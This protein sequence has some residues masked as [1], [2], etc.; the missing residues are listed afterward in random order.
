MLTGPSSKGSI[1]LT[2]LLLITATGMGATLDFSNEN[3]WATDTDLTYTE[4]T[5][6]CSTYDTSVVLRDADDPSNNITIS[7]SPNH[8]ITRGELVGNDNDQLG[9]RAGDQTIELY[10]GAGNSTNHT[11]TADVTVRTPS[12]SISDDGSGFVGQ[13]LGAGTGADPLTLAVGVNDLQKDQLTKDQ[14]SFRF[15]SIDGK[16]GKDNTYD[17]RL[18]DKGDM[19]I[20]PILNEYIP[21]ND[22]LTVHVNMTVDGETVRLGTKDF[23]PQTF[24]YNPRNINRQT[25]PQ[26]E[27][28]QFL[29]LGYLYRFDQGIEPGSD[30]DALKSEDIALTI[31][32]VGQNDL[33]DDKFTDQT[34]WINLDYHDNSSTR[35]ELYRNNEPPL[36]RG[37]FDFTVEILRPG[38]K[39][40]IV[41]DRFRVVNEKSV[42]G[43]IKQ[44]GRGGIVT[45]VF[46]KY[47]DGTERSFT[48]DSD[49]RYSF[50]LG[51]PVRY[52]E[53]SFF[54]RRLEQPDGRLTV[55]SPDFST[56]ENTNYET[57]KFEYY[58]NPDANNRNLPSGLNPVNMMAVKFGYHIDGDVSA[59]MKL[60]TKDVNL[61][62]LNMY[63]CVQWNML[64]EQCQGDWTRMD[65]SD[66]AYDPINNRVNIHSLTLRE[67]EDG[68]DGTSEIIKNAYVAGVPAQL[69]LD[70]NVRLNKQRLKAGG[71]LEVSGTVKSTRN[72]GV[73]DVTVELRLNGEDA[74]KTL[75]TETDSDGRFTVSGAVPDVPG[76]YTLDLQ[77]RKDPF[78]S[79][80]VMSDQS[81]EVYY[82]TGMV[83]D[84]Q[85]FSQQISMG[86]E[87]SLTF[88]I[89]NTGQ[90]P[91]TLDEVAVDG[92]P[93]DQLWIS[94]QPTTVPAGE[95]R[96][97]TMRV[98]LPEDFCSY[99]CS[100]T[101]E[102]N[103]HVEGTSAEKQLSAES[104]IATSIPVQPPEQA[105][106]Q[107]EQ[108][109]QTQEASFAG[110]TARMVQ[111]TSRM[112]QND[113][114]VA[115]GLILVFTVVLAAAIKRK[116]AQDGSGARGQR[117]ERGNGGRPQVQPRENKIA[118]PRVK[119]STA[120]DDPDTGSTEA[121]EDT[122]A[123]DDQDTDTPEQ[124]DGEYVCEATGE[125][126]DTKAALE[127]YKKMNDIDE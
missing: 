59:S 117:D 45:N 26:I 28:Q 41:I 98:R 62:D 31:E 30:A 46:L 116:K 1:L 97:A 23:R 43:I 109:N 83:L 64:G 80:Q 99:P 120:P 127:M 100:R 5:A 22:D 86:N 51:T 123:G 49:G 6:T 48:T 24:A 55:N 67:I 66:F 85:A 20:R 91:I 17:W 82:E 39:D 108:A 122:G 113:M 42:S 118:R 38:D 101:P 93:D 37:R 61:E 60:N 33:D 54:Q 19:L 110:P 11:T 9:L 63:E 2:A 3:V 88:D 18:T 34:N 104:S 47:S 12:F 29:N 71:E 13:K 35:V 58:E 65:E 10:C 94:D 16:I 102:I 84:T 125:T 78:V 44:P 77:L 57:I 56:E 111:F 79:N 112:T 32:Q 53:L 107:S 52:T 21:D 76:E 75:T 70:G 81:I 95:S 8:S 72:G 40:D 25:T 68:G 74:S 92:L 119:S 115:L 106:S 4:G 124:Q 7:A 114:N 90:A 73:D 87:T 89:K 105:S 121:D 14:F 36:P 103:I 15:S 27:F 96:Q 69:I 126:F 50:P